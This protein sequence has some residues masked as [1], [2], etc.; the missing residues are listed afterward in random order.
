MTT[1]QQLP[2]VDGL[3]I[4]QVLAETSRTFPLREA[5][6]FSQSRLRMS[7]TQFAAAVRE[8]AKGLLAL[9]IKPG[10]HVGIWATNLPEWTLLQFGAARIGAVLVTINPAYRQ[11]ELRYTLEHSDVVALFLT[12]TFKSSDYYT[13]FEE[14]CPEIA[15]AHDGKVSCA[16][17]PR[18]RRAIAIKPGA[19]RAISLGIP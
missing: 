9:D 3:T 19:P 17:F 15:R 16:S 2:W 14:A 6:V 11:F 1:Q 8:V 7:Y 13:I 5:L 10:E 4:G 18:L 12:D